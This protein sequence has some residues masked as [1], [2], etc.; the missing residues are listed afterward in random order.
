M[1][2]NPPNISPHKKNQNKPKKHNHFDRWTR[3]Y[4]PKKH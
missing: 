3:K 1:K 2:K 4:T